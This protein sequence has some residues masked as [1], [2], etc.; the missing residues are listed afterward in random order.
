M[1]EQVSV[2]KENGAFVFH[3]SGKSLLRIGEEECNT[4]EQLLARANELRAQAW[5]TAAIVGEFTQLAGDYDSE[6]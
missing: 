4:H 1:E 6:L 5:A 2:S 3:K